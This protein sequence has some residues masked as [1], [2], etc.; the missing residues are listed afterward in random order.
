[1]PPNRFISARANAAWL[2][3][4]GSIALFGVLVALLIGTT[5]KSSSRGEPLV[6]FC[7]AGVK[8]PVEAV[9]REYEK[10]FGVPIQLQYGGSQTL[11]ANL[12]IARRGDLYLPA[13]ASY[14]A[15]AREKQLIGETIPLARM[16]AVLA[17]RKGNPKNI[18]SLEDLLRGG[19][20][21]AQADPDQAA[22]GKLLRATLRAS[23]QWDELARRTA[24]FKPTVNDVANDLK[25]GAADAGFVWDALLQQ[26]PE[27]EAVPVPALTN[28]V[29]NISIAVLRSSA[30]PAAALRFARHLAARDRGLSEWQR[31]GYEAVADGPNLNER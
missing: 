4:L 3:F 14:L 21:I 20:T 31:H 11:L 2:A 7:A 10:K 29:A 15:L 6:V 26:N 8:A 22:I 16:R 27:I 9:A 1:M 19:A 18:R 25:L 23:G 30:Q 28:V 24:V 5:E 13:D 17:V 12:T